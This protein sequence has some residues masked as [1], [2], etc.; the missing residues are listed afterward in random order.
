MDHLC[1]LWLVCG[2]LLHLVVTCRERSDLFA[3]VNCDFV[4][5]PFGILG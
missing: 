3:L 2:M 4:S 1:Q 5:F